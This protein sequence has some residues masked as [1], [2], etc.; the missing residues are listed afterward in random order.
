M[1][2][3]L[4]FIQHYPHFSSY[5][6]EASLS[7]TGT[8]ENISLPFSVPILEQVAVLRFSWQWSW[9]WTSNR[10]EHTHR[11]RQ[12]HYLFGTEVKYWH[13]WRRID[14]REIW[15]YSVINLRGLPSQQRNYTEKHF[16]ASC[17]WGCYTPLYLLHDSLSHNMHLIIFETE[18][19]NNKFFHLLDW[20][21][22]LWTTNGNKGRTIF[23]FIKRP[24]SQFNA[25][26]RGFQTLLCFCISVLL[27]PAQLLTSKIIA[28]ALVVQPH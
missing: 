21:R 18:F 1:T 11:A 7:K 5:A 23:F 2:S 26:W 27:Q 24:R 10:H 17:R 28:N 25:D 14:L 9:A 4:L 20:L 12:L 6:S 16:Q 15:G 3:V 22:H 8:W 13:D 19:M